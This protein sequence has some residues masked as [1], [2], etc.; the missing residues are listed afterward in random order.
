MYC[1]PKK[2]L[3]KCYSENNIKTDTIYDKIRSYLPLKEINENPVLSS[4]LTQEKKIVFN[5]LTSNK[6]KMISTKG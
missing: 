4:A 2:I 5:L 6:S 1:I 3:Q